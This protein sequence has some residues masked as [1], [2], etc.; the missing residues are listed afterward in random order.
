ERQRSMEPGV[1]LEIRQRMQ[2]GLLIIREPMA[3]SLPMDI[4]VTPTIN[5]PEEIRIV[6]SSCRGLQYVAGDGLHMRLLVQA[7]SDTKSVSSQNKSLK[8]QRSYSFY[9]QLC[10]EIIIKERTFLRVLPL[11]SEHWG[12]LVEEWCCHPSPF[13]SSLLHPLDDDCLLGD[14]YVLVNSGSKSHSESQQPASKSKEN[15]RVI[16]KR[17]K[18]MLGETIDFFSN[19]SLF[20]QNVVAQCLVEL[21]SARSTFRFRIQ[22]H[23]GKTYILMWLLNSDTLLVESMG[24]SD[25][26][27]TFT[28]FEDHLRTSFMSSDTWNAIKVL[29]LPSALVPSPKTIH[30]L[31]FPSKTCLELLLIMSL[32]NASLP[33]SLQCLNSFQVKKCLPFILYIY[34]AV[35]SRKTRMAPTGP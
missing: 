9:C 30:L 7:D 1:F 31:T 26:S 17:C 24:N 18:A 20:V 23:D 8:A 5:L 3:G 29:F 21:S 34:K 33:P 10:G 13:A 14:T 19:R 28:L 25:T 16:C 35:V 27:N 32:N 22:G 4:S 6:P 15:T 12:A 11:P 2:S